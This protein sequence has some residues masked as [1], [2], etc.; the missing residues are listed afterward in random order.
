MARARAKKRVLARQEWIVLVLKLLDR[1]LEKACSSL[2]G[3][4]EQQQQIQAPT[5]GGAQVVRVLRMV[6][7]KVQKMVSPWAWHQRSQLCW[8]LWRWMGLRQQPGLW[9]PCQIQRSEQWFQ[10]KV[11]EKK[12]KRCFWTQGQLTFFVELWMEMNGAW[13]RRRMFR[14]QLESVGWERKGLRFWQTMRCRP[15][16]RWGCWQVKAWRLTGVVEAAVFVILV[17]GGFQLRLNRTVPMFLAG[18]AEDWLKTWRWSSTVAAAW[19]RLFAMSRWRMQRCCGIGGL[20]RSG[21]RFAQMSK[22]SGCWLRRR[23]TRMP[24]RSTDTRGGESE[25]QNTLPSIC[26]LV[27]SR[28]GG[29]RECRSQW[30]SFA[31]IFWSIRTWWTTTWWRTWCRWFELREWLQ[32]LGAR[33][34]EVFQ[35]WGREMMVDLDNFVNEK[36]HFVGHVK[37]FR[38]QNIKWPLEC[39]AVASFLGFGERREEKVQS[40]GRTVWNPRRSSFVLAWEKGMPIVYNLAWDSADYGSGGVEE[41][42]TGSG[43]SWASSEETDMSLVRLGRSFVVRWH[44]RWENIEGMAVSVRWCGEGVAEVGFLGTSLEKN[45]GECSTQFCW[46]T[47]RSSFLCRWGEESG[48]LVWPPAERAHAV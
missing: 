8:S 42:L 9:G 35:F 11:K 21:F 45:S 5:L 31:S 4:E 30:R 29:H 33:L 40:L 20:W 2:G 23:W 36:D 27:V 7:L 18:G 32:S 39:W 14:Q 37:G 38:Q 22:W 46:W 44:A 43:M 17:L 28:V 48:G 10:L 15:S 13:R 47:S 24:C 3:V 41:D 12:I 26:S 16:F 25:G 34:A 6:V 19:S 1:L